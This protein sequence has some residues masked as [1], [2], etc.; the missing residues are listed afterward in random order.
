MEPFTAG[1]SHQIIELKIMTAPDFAELAQLQLTTL[2]SCNPDGQLRFIREPEYDEVDPAPRFFMSRTPTKNIWRF[3]YDLPAD[4]A[5]SL[6]QVCLQ[7]PVSAELAQPPRYREQIQ[8]IL[9][10]HRPVTDAWRGPAYWIPEQPS[11][12]DN[13]VLITESNA[14]LLQAHFPWKITSKA[15]F[16]TSPLI[17][18]V[19][20]HQAVSI[21]YC[22]RITHSAAEAGVE[23]AEGFRGY[24]YAGLAVGRWAET[25]RQSGRVPLYSTSWDNTASQKVASKLNL[26]NYADN[27]SIT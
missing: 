2:F 14:S 26:L 6:Q 23:T 16:K 5:Q 27:W 3:R 22:A 20:D 15:N 24:G 21:C 19:V 25:M 1:P 9:N 18:A 4:V 13:V 7:E 17:A 12:S 8:Q 10:K 11:L